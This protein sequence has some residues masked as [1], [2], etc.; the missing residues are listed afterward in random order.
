MVR[1]AAVALLRFAF[2]AETE[3]AKLMYFTDDACA[4]AASPAHKLLALK[5]CIATGESNGPGSYIATCT[6][7]TVTMTN[8]DDVACATAATV[9]NSGSTEPDRMGSSCKSNGPQPCKQ[10]VDSCPT[11]ECTR[12]DLQTAKT[13][14]IC[15]VI[16]AVKK[17][18]SSDNAVTA[19]MA[20][21]VVLSAAALV[22]A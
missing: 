2:A 7:T 20:G 18:S 4:T 3:V 19:S 22:F 12:M 14:M 15:T 5:E 6:G 13:D 17:N 1:I 16:K 10:K 8:Y 21:V 11:M 9:E